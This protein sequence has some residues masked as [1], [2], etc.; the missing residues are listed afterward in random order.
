MIMNSEIYSKDLGIAELPSAL[1]QAHPPLEQ[2][3]EP[4]RDPLLIFWNQIRPGFKSIPYSLCY[5]KRFRGS[6]FSNK[7]V[8]EAYQNI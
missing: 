2:A 7:K 1:P 6:L 3:P 5:S 8:N 4:V